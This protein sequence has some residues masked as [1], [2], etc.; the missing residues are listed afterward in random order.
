MFADNSLRSYYTLTHSLWWNVKMDLEYI[1]KMIPYE[2]DIR[3][4]L[5]MQSLEEEKQQ[6]SNS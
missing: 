6:N 4:A 1:E 2:L 3:I 5:I